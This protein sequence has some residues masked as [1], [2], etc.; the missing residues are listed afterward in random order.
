VLEDFVPN[1]VI[2]GLMLI[3][4]LLIVIVRIGMLQIFVGFLSGVAA[5]V[6]QG[7]TGFPW[8]NI[9]LIVLCVYSVV[10]TMR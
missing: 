3:N 8:L 4:I 9:M 5:A 2:F 7:T 6:I 1:L 10:D